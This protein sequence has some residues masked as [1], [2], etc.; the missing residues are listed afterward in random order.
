MEPLVLCPDDQWLDQP[1]AEELS[2]VERLKASVQ[3]RVERAN[4]PST[5]ATAMGWVERFSAATPSRALFMRVGGV[6][7]AQAMAYN[8]QTY[9]LL[10]EY[11]T[12]HGSVQPGHRGKKLDPATVSGY[13]G[14]LKAAMESLNPKWSALR[15]HPKQPQSQSTNQGT[16]LFCSLSAW[17]RARRTDSNVRSRGGTRARRL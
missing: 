5:L 2:L 6:D 7:N 11:I 1:S 10:G 3:S 4:D 16:S 13:M 17:A 12:L 8:A 9:A 15:T 14:V